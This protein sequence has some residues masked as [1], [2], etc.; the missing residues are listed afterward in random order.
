LRAVAFKTSVLF[1][2]SIHNL[3]A[4]RHLPQWNRNKK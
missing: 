2:V 3:L 4:V 1:N